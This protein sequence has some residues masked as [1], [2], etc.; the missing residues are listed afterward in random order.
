MKSMNLSP[1]SPVG[2]CPLCGGIL[3]REVIQPVPFDCPHCSA[4][5]RPSHRPSYLWLRFT[6]TVG[7]GIAAARLRGFDWSF[8]VFVVGF[9]AL[10]A[11]FF[12]DAIVWRLFPPRRF[13]P[14][15]EY[16]Q[17]LGIDQR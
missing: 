13:E 17:T 12:W 6:V 4:R 1:G 7:I 8:L 11:L 14:A 10:P 15:P 2:T 5:I 9:F 3:T 16:V